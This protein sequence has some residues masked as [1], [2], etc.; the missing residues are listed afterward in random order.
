MQLT[1]LP[2]ISSAP[3]PVLYENAKRALAE[4][5]RIDECQT[6]ANKAE[7]L[8]RRGGRFY[9]CGLRV[10]GFSFARASLSTPLN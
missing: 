6:W 7:A 2:S 8:A 3:L 10:H 4:C 1:T 5:S 9:Q